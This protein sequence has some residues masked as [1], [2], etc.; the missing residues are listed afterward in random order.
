MCDACKLLHRLDLAR[1]RVGAAIS[2][3]EA[4]IGDRSPGVAAAAPRRLL[5]LWLT[6][7]AWAVLAVVL[8][9]PALGGG[10]VDKLGDTDDALRLVLV[11]DLVQGHAGWYDQHFARLQPPLGMD[12][13]WSRLVDG[14]IA[15]VELLFRLFLGPERAEY[16]A[17]IAWP[18]LWIGPAVAAMI[19]LA[20]RLRGDNAAL[21]CAALLAVNGVLFWQWA[22]GR[23]DHHDLQMTAA[24][25]ALAGVV[26]GSRRGAALAG[27][28]TAAGLAVGIEALLFLGLV[29]G[30]VAL[31]W[32]RDPVEH[33][34][35][36]QAYAAALLLGSVALYLAQTP[37]AWWGLARCDALGANLLLAVAAA[38]LGLL[39][40][41]CSPVASGRAGRCAA[42]AAVAVVAAGLFLALEPACLH[43]PFALSDARIKP[44]WLGKVAEMQPLLTLVR[45]HDVNAVSGLLMIVLGLPAWVWLGRRK[46]QRTVIWLMVGACFLAAAAAGV[47]VVRLCG[48]ASLF[49]APLIAAAGADFAERFGRLGRSLA[50][51]LVVAV[52]P[53]WP[54]AAIAD[55]APDP[56]SHAAPTPRN[57]AAPSY[58]AALA[59]LRP[60]IVLNEVDLGPF[61][62]AA[63]PHS[64]LAGPYHRADWGILAADAAL[65]APPGRDE[66]A[67]RRLHAD[68]VVDCRNS[69]WMPRR[70]EIGPQSLQVRL[71]RGR[72][73][74]WLEPLSRPEAAL[75]VYRVRPAPAR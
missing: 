73:P 34:R 27:L 29:G 71:D 52:S 54:A 35:P 41:T 15:A 8:A 19:F 13:H 17:R 69:A 33:T 59:K 40:A 38:C 4:V 67:V 23:I 21:A 55:P 28:A 70:Q 14:G 7:A 5:V 53:S 62:L 12:L 49:A 48:Y 58:Y 31:R 24:L 39:G 61:I 68:Y 30:F 57:C 51:V 45:R 64:V 46:A 26:A 56:G 20:R 43:G 50:V 9:A 2:S 16:A 75:Q 72:A 65:A 60:G 3:S 44:V 42:L 63:T 25:G 18:L 1:L 6:L 37:P 36:A 32:A 11:R 10:L 74:A 47:H 22:P 66:A